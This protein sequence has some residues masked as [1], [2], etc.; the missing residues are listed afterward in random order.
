MHIW[1]SFLND[2]GPDPNISFTLKIWRNNPWRPF[3]FYRKYDFAPGQYTWQLYDVYSNEHFL[4]PSHPTP[5]FASDTEV[6][7]YNFNIS[8]KPF[9]QYEGNIYMLEAQAFTSNP[10]FVFGW[11]S[12]LPPSQMNNAIWRRGYSWNPLV[13]PVTGDGMD[14][15]FVIATAP[16]PPGFLLLGTGLV[17]LLGFE[18]RRRH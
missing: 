3:D 11:E 5:P 18:L 12:A 6:Y 15:A 16:I 9:Y 4:D 8:M 2:A 10:D 1:G 7:F 13:N 14:L 17:G